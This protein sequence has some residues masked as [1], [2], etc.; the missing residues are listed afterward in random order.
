MNDQISVE[1]Q[2]KLQELQVLEHNLQALLMQ[3]QAFQLEL[4][5]S[6]N[7]LDEVRKT[8]DTIYK[9][10]GSIMVIVDKNDTIKELEE[11]KKLLEMRS[12]SITKQEHLI[13][14]KARELQQEIKKALEKKSPSTSAKSK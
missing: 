3:K 4:N 14:A 10:V 9:M 5:E 7:A 6:L 8:N 2:Q 1:A 11:K 12:D 13:E